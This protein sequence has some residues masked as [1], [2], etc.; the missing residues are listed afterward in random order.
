MVNR[1]ELTIIIVNWNT[2]KLLKNCLSS[3]EATCGHDI[4]KTIV[5]DNA[6]TDGSREMVKKTFPFVTLIDTGGNIG[7]AK[8]NNKGLSVA[9][10]PFVLFLNP[11]T[12]VCEHAIQG[13]LRQIKNDD[14]IGAISCQLYSFRGSG[15]NYDSHEGAHTLGLQWFPNPF[16]EM[17][18][19]YLLSDKMINTL[20]KVLPFHDPCKSGYVKKLSGAVLLVRKSVLDT[21]G[22][23]DER[24]FM[25]L[26]D[27]DLS[28]R[29]GSAGWR[30]YYLA[31]SRIMHICGGASINVKNQFTTLMMCESMEKY[32]LKYFK[33][34]GYY[35]YRGIAFSGSIYRLLLLA[36]AQL[37]NLVIGKRPKRLSESFAWNKYVAMLEWS[38]GRKKLVI[39]LTN[40]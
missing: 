10:S 33:A 3:I 36:T 7:F 6:S 21:V 29:I 11:D 12:V 20:K 14:S 24:F 27:A 38:V 30:L 39:E 26:E 16:T 4:V 34:L 13:M 37:V 31:S 8:G 17:L 32:F 22:S 35:I 18:S 23:F 9:D 40:S 5:V 19:I 28:K 15:G 1:I 25:Y 2:A